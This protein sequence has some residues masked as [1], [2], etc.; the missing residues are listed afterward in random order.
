MEWTVDLVYPMR[1][2]N[3]RECRPL[4]VP[5]IDIEVTVRHQACTDFECLLPK[6]EVLSL[7]LDLDV[8]DIPSLSIHRGHGQREGNYD[9][10]PALRRLIARK[11]KY[12]RLEYQHSLS[13]TFG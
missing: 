2:E 5:S 9:S 13:A 10:L 6:K 8:I 12:I 3:W 1:R 7:S 11:A 4:D